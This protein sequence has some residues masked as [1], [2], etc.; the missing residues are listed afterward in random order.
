VE[1]SLDA[2]E[3]SGQLPDIEITMCG[4]QVDSSPH[5]GNFSSYRSSSGFEPSSDDRSLVHAREEIS[6]KR[7]NSIRGIANLER[8]DESLYQDFETEDIRKVCMSF[9]LLI[10]AMSADNQ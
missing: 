9:L 5:S 4:P 8:V 2:A 6:Q 3:S 10:Y 1:N 7:M